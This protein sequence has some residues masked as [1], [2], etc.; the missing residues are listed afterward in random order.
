VTDAPLIDIRGVAKS[1]GGI[2]PL[3]LRRFTVMAGDR[4]VLSGFDQGAA[5]TFV[6]L[7]SGALVPDEGVVSV[8]GMDTRAIATDT[9]WLSSLDRFGIVTHRAVLVEALSIAANLALPLTL[10]VDPMTPVTRGA[11]D[12]LASDVGL[13]VDRLDAAASTLTPLERTRVHLARALAQRPQ[14]VL[15]EHPTAPL[16]SEAD[17]AAVGRQLRDVAARRGLGWVAISEDDAFARATGAT[18]MRLRPATGELQRS[19]HVWP[20]S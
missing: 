15:L 11:V 18:W 19:G 13:P 14:L 16:V 2:R 4:F 8:A 7:V 20:W 17:R 6:H 3:R 1:Y 10:A 9:E 5:E 12:A